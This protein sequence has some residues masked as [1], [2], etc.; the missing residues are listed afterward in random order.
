MRV[1]TSEQ[2]REVDR[3][4]IEEGVPSIALMENAA[5][6]V[7]E[8][9][10]REFDPIDRQNIVILCGKGNNGGDGLAIARLLHEYRVGRLRVV[11]AADPSEFTGDA[12]ENLKRVRELGIHPVFQVPEKLRERREVNVVVDALL[13]TGLKGPPTGRTAELIRATRDFPQARIVAVD[14]PSGLGGGGD[15]VRA[16]IT[17]TFTAPKVEHYLAPGAEEHVGRLVVSQIGSPP[18]L[19][20]AGLE[21]SSPADFRHLFRPRKPDAHKGDF[22]HVLVVGGAPGKS[23]AA[24]MAGIAALRAGAGLVTVACSDSSKLALELMSESLDNFSLERKTV[25]AVGPGLGERR[26]LVPNLL[27]DVG[28]PTVIDAD[29]LNA[30][31][32]TD[33]RGRGL[34][35]VLTPHPGEM[36]R[37]LGVERISE[38][39]RLKV[40]RTFAQER[41]VCLVLKGYRTLIALP[42]GN[43]W[44]NTTGSPAM[45]TG[46]TGDILTGMIS[47]MIGQ[48]PNEIDTAVRAAVWLHGRA[49]QLGAQELTEQC[50]IATD[51][52]HYLPKAIREIV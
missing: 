15:C 8:E 45:A 48:F 18:W 33:F 12:A 21:V 2:M 24:A 35:T 49:G 38:D 9:M 10:V 52:L 50:L 30:I 13:G 5:H 44:I 51:L 11:L 42:D 25:L 6:R 4:T 17:V 32:G 37:L 28:I 41:N 40:A 27:K 7:V 36:A 3:L 19:I 39:D 46:G 22:G 23:G 16:D 43:V 34:H 26:G 1:L 14:M 20:P 29:G 31:A 47:G